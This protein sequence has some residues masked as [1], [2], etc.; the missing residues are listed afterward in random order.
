VLEYLYEHPI[1]SVNEVKELIGTAYPAAS[2][3]VAKL[4]ACGILTE[5]TGQSRNRRFRYDE[6]VHL[7]SD[8]EVGRT[9]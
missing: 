5:I 9:F 2:Q 8:A 1:V 4:E 7:F 3:L 6:Y